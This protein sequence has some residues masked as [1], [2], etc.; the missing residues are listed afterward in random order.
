MAAASESA[1]LSGAI[2]PAPTTVQYAVLERIE[3]DGLA[4]VAEFGDPYRTIREA[5]ET[6]QAAHP[7]LG[8]S[9]GYVGGVGLHCGP[10]GDDRSWS[11]F[12]KLA[13]PR[14]HDACDVSFGGVATDVVEDLAARMGEPFHAWLAECER[15]LD[16][17]EI[18]V[19][20]P[21][22]LAA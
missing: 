18:R 2:V 1:R 11:V 6:A 12:A 15:R 9:F 13:T 7:R 14:C 3:K 4:R 8:L 16:A 20:G 17:G 5:V 19:V 10:H 22:S 21:A